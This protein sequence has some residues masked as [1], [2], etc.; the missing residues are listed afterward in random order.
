MKTRTLGPMKTKQL[1][2]SDLFITPVGFGAWAIGGSGWEFAW[3]A[4]DDSESIA[5]GRGAHLG[6]FPAPFRPRIR[7]RNQPL[8]RPAPGR[9]PRRLRRRLPQ[10]AGGAIGLSGV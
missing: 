5:G 1:G 2:N 8:E 4:Q 10:G 3:G 7:A 9:D 6:R